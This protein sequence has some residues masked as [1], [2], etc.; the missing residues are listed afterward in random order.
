MFN[1]VLYKKQLVGLTIHL[2]YPSSDVVI[3]TPD[4]IGFNLK[5]Q[6][7]ELGCCVIQYPLIGGVS[8]DFI[9]TKYDIL[10]GHPRQSR[11]S[12]FAKLQQKKG[13]GKILVLHPFCPQDLFTYGYLYSS[14]L[15]AD[16][17]LAIT[18]SYWDKHLPDTIFSSWAGKIT[19]L[20]LA[21][22]RQNFPRVKYNFNPPGKR[23]FLFV[24]NHPHFKNVDFL[25][26]L[27]KRCSDIEFHRIGPPGKYPSLIQHG[28]FK[29]ND[30]FVVNLIK[31]MDFMITMGVMDANPTTVL[32]CASMGLIAVC[33]EG[34]GYYESDG[35]FNISGFNL[36][37]AVITV[38][39]LNSLPNSCLEQKRRCM[40]ELLNKR[41]TWERFAL[42]IVEQVLVSSN[43]SYKFDISI[44]LIKIKLYLFFHKKAFWRLAIS[45]WLKDV[46]R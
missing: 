17:F 20:D 6:L 24:G 16:S 3:S 25:N 12:T 46:F 32:E 31:E 40:D 27:A 26:K 19:Q 11:H 41:Y 21:V 10:L 8:V 44:R 39:E 22:D 7:N 1:H 33:P 14:C 34:S 29:L 28:S 4:A 13:W 2:V 30:P 18:G 23:K 38:N 5:K 35:V 43:N 37:Q 42:K 36:N 45:D 15:K 9:P